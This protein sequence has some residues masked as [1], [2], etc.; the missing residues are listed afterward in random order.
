ML[1]SKQ[2]AEKCDRSDSLVEDSAEPDARRVAV[3]DEQLVE[4]WHLEDGARCEGVFERLECALSLRV[5]RESNLAEESGQGRRDVAEVADEFS[6]VPCHPRIL[7][8]LSAERG[9]GHAETVATLLASMAM[10]FAEMTWPRYAIKGAPNEH[11]M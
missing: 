6:V 2:V 9:C 7:R 10:S 4:V 1:G 11:L 5:P 3:D 8:R